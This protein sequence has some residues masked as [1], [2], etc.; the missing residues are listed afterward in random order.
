MNHIQT[1]FAA[2]FLFSFGSISQSNANDLRSDAPIMDKNGNYLI[3]T[4]DNGTQAFVYAETPQTTEGPL[5]DKDGN[6]IIINHED[7]T[8]SFA[9]PDTEG[10]SSQTTDGPLLDKDGNYIIINHEDGTQ[11][12]A[13][14]E[15]DDQ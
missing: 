2:I 6:Y 13:Y 3:V 8:Q 10:K 7:G 1:L 4:L 12:F 15:H 9:Y 5:L 14:P 11:S